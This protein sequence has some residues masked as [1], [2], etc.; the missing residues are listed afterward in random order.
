MTCRFGA[1][2]TWFRLAAHA[3]PLSREGKSAVDHSRSRRRFSEEEFE[4]LV[5]DES[6]PLVRVPSY[7]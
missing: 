1:I 2:S 5:R 7:V 4:E 6:L 3:V